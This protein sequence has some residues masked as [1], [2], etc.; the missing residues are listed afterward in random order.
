[1]ENASKA[2][3]IAGGILLAMLTAGLIVLLVNNIQTMQNA[4][5]EKKAQEQLVAFNRGYEA[6]NKRIMYGTD[7][8]SVVNKAIQ[9]NKSMDLVADPTNAYYI[10]ITLVITQDF[11]TEKITTDDYYPKDNDL[12]QNTETLEGVSIKKGTYRLG[13]WDAE[14]KLEMKEEIITFFNTSTQT[15]VKKSKHYGSDANITEIT[16]PALSN[17]KKSVFTCSNVEYN[18]NGRIK[19]MTFTQVTEKP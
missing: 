4:Q 9:N 8:I 1:M 13:N 11:I 6:Y 5:S 10:N 2:L 12:Y 18:E 7:V 16:Y 14:S 19:E 3:L 17:F 15:E